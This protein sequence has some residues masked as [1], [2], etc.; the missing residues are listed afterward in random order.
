MSL[1]HA[2]ALAVQGNEKMSEET[3]AELDTLREGS[4]ELHEEVAKL[5]FTIQQKEVEY[6][7]L[8]LQL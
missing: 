4:K 2:E 7:Q 1:A 6:G 3:V 8:R 5:Q